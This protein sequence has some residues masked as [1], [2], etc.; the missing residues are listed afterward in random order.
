VTA[1][2]ARQVWLRLAVVALL[3]LTGTAL[4]RLHLHALPASDTVDLSAYAMPD[5]TLPDLCIV[6]EPAGDHAAAP[7]H[8]FACRLVLAAAVLPGTAAVGRPLGPPVEARFASA[9][10]AVPADPD[11]QP[12]RARSPPT[13]S[14]A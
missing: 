6:A 2:I 5:G 10:T 4:P 1:F 14:L 11:W 8:C 9:A 7:P 3:A 13:A 12:N